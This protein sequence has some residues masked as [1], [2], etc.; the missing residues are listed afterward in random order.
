MPYM[1]TKTKSFCLAV[2][3]ELAS[4][5]L[6]AG[7]SAPLSAPNHHGMLHAPRREGLNGVEHY[8]Y[9]RFVRSPADVWVHAEEARR[10]ESVR[11]PAWSAVRIIIQTNMPVEAEAGA[12]TTSLDTRCPPIRGRSSDDA[13]YRS[14]RS[15]QALRRRD[16]S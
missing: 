12:I 10:I 7:P 5:G 2:H 15:G 9:A 3:D 16:G 1:R 6:L 11:W 4:A 8:P 14:P 13:D